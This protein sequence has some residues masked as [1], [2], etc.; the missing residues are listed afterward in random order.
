[1]V[2]IK[3]IKIRE[4]LNSV[5]K[6]TIEVEIRTGNNISA[7]SSSPSAIIPGKR[8]TITTNKVSENKLNEMINEVC[9]RELK[10]QEEIDTILESYINELGANICL[11]FSLAFARVMAQ[12]QNLTLVEYISK[13]AN[14]KKQRTSPIPLIAIFSGGVHN[15]KEKG[16]IQNIMLAVDIHPFSKAIQAITDIYSY[17]ENELKKKDILKA[18]GQSSG[19]IVEEIAI[20]EKFKMISDTIKTLNYEKEVTIAI[21]VAA[22]HLFKDEIYTYQGKKIK[23][24]ELNKILNEYIEKYNITYIE[25]PFDSKDEEYWKKMKLENKTIC[26]VGDDL[27][28]TQDKYI[29]NKLANGIII[30]MNQ[31]GTLT[32]TIKAFCKAKEE[33]MTICVSQR[34]IETEDTFMCDLAVALNATYIKIGGPRRGD[35]IAKYN[36]LLRLEEQ[37]EEKAYF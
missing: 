17:I 12:A 37:E 22:E 18:Y 26:I 2:K 34:S 30:K 19:M 28:A 6:K 23:S 4:I 13:I 31:V 3:E 20:D 11:P 9:N 27:F 32:G 16:S 14:Y 1:M 10:N 8:E 25:D 36:R 15:Q 21:D 7:I 29:N 33:N 5:G 35:R 24:K